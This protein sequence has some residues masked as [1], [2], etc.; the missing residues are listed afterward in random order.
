MNILAI[1]MG[2]G[3]SRP[4]SGGQN[5]FFNV[6]AELARKGNKVVVLERNDLLD[7]HDHELAT[8]YTYKD[9]RL[10]KRTLTMFRDLDVHFV[11][12]VLSI[13]RNEKIDIV[14]IRY[15]SGTLAAR[16]VATLTL[17][18][19]P[20]V[21][22]AHNVECNM[23]TES[24]AKDPKYTKLERLVVPAY[25][26]VLE[27][28]ACRHLTQH[29]V[30]VSEE[31]KNIFVSRYN[32][33]AE[34]VTVIPSGC[35]ISPLPNKESKE[36]AKKGLGIDLDKIVI[37][38]HGL[39]SWPPNKDA[40]DLIESYIAPR[41]SEIN[42]S[43][44]FILG[45]TGVPVFERDNIKS[46]GFIEDL[47]EALVAADIAIVPIVRGAGTRTK[48]LD[49]LGMGLPIVSTR[50]GIEGINAMN[51]E[52]ALI[53]DEVDEEFIELTA[54]LVNSVQER[55]RI[56]TNAYRLADREYN[57]HRIGDR[58]CQLY[59]HLVNEQL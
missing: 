33:P 53:T 47:D 43:V 3:L 24:F 48:I 20:V 45:G 16:L 11:L 35:H 26:K 25:I 55:E 44:V 4:I 36:S 18:R 1:P 6:V 21:Y 22:S 56:G 8:I 46:L 58:L 28:F 13:V 37:F 31:D 51:G 10:F 49:Y 39:F 12:Q 52:E 54:R 34:K 38:F 17:N 14:H 30:A 19:I 29:I 41:F 32:L 7:P 59:Q 42:E 40:F 15:P 57:W 23:I 2:H 5:R 27:R 9:Y 50:K